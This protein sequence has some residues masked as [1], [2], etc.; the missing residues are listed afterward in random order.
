MRRERTPPGSPGPPGR[1]PRRF[2]L[3]RRREIWW[4]TWQGGLLLT[5]ASVALLLIFVLTIYRF[6][7]PIDPARGPDGRGARTLVVEG[8][9]DPPV[10]A[11][12]AAIARAGRYERILTTGGRIEAWMDRRG[13]GSFAV[14]AADLLQAEGGLAIPIVAVP[15]P[16]SAQERT[17]Q[18]ALEVRRWIEGQSGERAGALDVFTSDVHARRTRM[19][20]RLAFGPATEIGILADR[21]DDPSAGHWWSR[22]D[23]A[24]RVLGEAIGWAWTACCFWPEVP[25]AP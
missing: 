13:W 21:S 20:Y 18:S 14:R 3:V 23:S 2:E 9:V 19:D 6:L 22:S 8:W 10:L 16:D 12:A 24:K 25:N 7:A 5:G 1:A 4:P 11:R 17:F 15:S